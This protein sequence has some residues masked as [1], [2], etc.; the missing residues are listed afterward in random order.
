MPPLPLG[1]RIAMHT[2]TAVI[3]WMVLLLAYAAVQS[4]RTGVTVGRGSV[5]AA[6]QPFGF[7]LNVAVFIV[8]AVYLGFL[9]VSIGR[10]K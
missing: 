9:A 1:H 8:M 4:L 10:A 2:A 5:A 6:D 3:C 7:Y